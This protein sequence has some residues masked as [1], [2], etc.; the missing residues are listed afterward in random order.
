MQ[1]RGK[2]KVTGHWSLIAYCLLP[3]AAC[4]EVGGKRSEERLSGGCRGCLV[5]VV[6]Q[7]R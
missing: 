7:T 1:D 4:S 5:V 3:G 2:G 6:V